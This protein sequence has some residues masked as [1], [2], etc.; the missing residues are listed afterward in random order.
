[1]NANFKLIGSTAEQTSVKLGGTKVT[2]DRLQGREMAMAV[3]TSIKA[4]N[5]GAVGGF[6]M[7]RSETLHRKTIALV[8]KTSIKAGGFRVNRCEIAQRQEK[9]MVVK[10][11]VKAGNTG[12]SFGVH[13]NRCE[14]TQRKSIALVVKT[15]VKAGNIG[16]VGGFR[17]NRCENVLGTKTARR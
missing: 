9:A 7:N 12:C 11:G 5:T 8:V 17:V 16:A 6:R 15:S 1:M 4:G 14:T 10:T 2:A 3:K 13:V